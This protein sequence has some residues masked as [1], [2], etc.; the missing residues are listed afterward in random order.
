MKNKSKIAITK[1]IYNNL[2]SDNPFKDIPLEKLIFQWWWTGRSTEGLRLSE[3]GNQACSLID[4]E[5][6]DFQFPLS[7]E[8]HPYIGVTLGKALK[9]PYYIGFNNRFY[10]SAYIRVYD[11]K[12]AMLI[13][14]YGGM[15]DYIES[16]K[17]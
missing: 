7:A 17:K 3:A 2:P 12:I 11:S 13:T 5:Y 10:K 1:A 6:F 14:L 4:L 9:C 15:K 16:V 8:A